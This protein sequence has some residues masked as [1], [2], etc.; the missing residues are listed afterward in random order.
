[1]NT[2]LVL[3]KLR[4]ARKDNRSNI[5]I[6]LSAIPRDSKYFDKGYDIEMINSP[7]K[8]SENTNTNDIVEV[9]DKPVIQKEV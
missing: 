3:K 9:S 4:Q 8:D 2:S 6:K 5:D 7:I 1:M